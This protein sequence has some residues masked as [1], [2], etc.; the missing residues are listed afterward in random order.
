MSECRICLNSDKGR[1][2]APCKCN[3]TIKHIHQGCLMRWLKEKY[4][5]KF[6]ALLKSHKS[7]NTGLQC[8]LCKYEFKGN[9][10]YLNPL[11]ILRKIKSSSL[12]YCV[13][14]NIP[15]IIYLAYKSNTLLR[16]L[17][18]FI[19]DQA[20]Q[21]N[22]STAASIKIL[23]ILKFYLKLCVKLFPVSIVATVFPMILHSTYTLTSKLV[24]EFKTIQF[25]DTI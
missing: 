25:E 6:S 2:V 24:M 8:E 18:C 11:Q 13:M 19:Y 9:I 3:G 1:L 14:M 22:R 16:H 21:L 5:S 7:K 23:A 10:K 20:L 15:I 12:T 4:P 17:F